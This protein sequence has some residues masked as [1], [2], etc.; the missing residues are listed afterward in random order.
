MTIRMILPLA[1]I[2]LGAATLAAPA[3][4]D[5]RHAG[6]RCT[7]A[8]EQAGARW[9]GTYSGTAP[10]GSFPRAWSG[11][12]CFGSQAECEAWLNAMTGLYSYSTRYSYCRRA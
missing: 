7:P 12:R 10:S 2:A 6:V 8:S 4:S 1:A 5:P 11:T 9:A 3:Q